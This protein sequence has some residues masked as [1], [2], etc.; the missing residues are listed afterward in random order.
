MMSQLEAFKNKVN[1]DENLRRQAA[2][3]KSAD[4]VVEFAMEN[5]FELSE[6]DIEEISSVSMDFLQKA[7]G[8]LVSAANIP[9]FRFF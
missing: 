9:A 5:G 1:S 2:E 4:D 6:E 3:L 8:G 7:A